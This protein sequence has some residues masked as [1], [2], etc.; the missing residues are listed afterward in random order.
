MS[1][2]GALVREEPQRSIITA[3]GGRLHPF[4]PGKSG[5]P[6]GRSRRFHEVQLA[7]REASPEAIAALVELVNSDD[8]R[9]RIIAANSILDRAF[10]KPKEQKDDSNQALKPNLSA[11][12]SVELAT[13]RGILAR[14]AGASEAQDV[15][16]GADQQ[17]NGSKT[18]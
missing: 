16:Q 9:V 1:S 15:V 4:V 2:D 7:A 5:N 11:L 8:E 13:L 14:M 17:E 12:S 10:G 3:T 18:E 6:T